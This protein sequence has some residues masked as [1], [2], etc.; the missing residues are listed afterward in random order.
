VSSATS[1]AGFIAAGANGR[2]DVEVAFGTRITAVRI[3]GGTDDIDS[4][5][6]APLH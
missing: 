4:A 6:S 1:V 3:F 5:W 2:C